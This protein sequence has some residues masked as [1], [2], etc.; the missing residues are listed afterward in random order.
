MLKF[1]RGRKR[2]RNAVLVIFI[3]VLTLSL[4]ALFSASGSGARM[5]GGTAGSDTVIA[6][7]GSY[8]VTVQDL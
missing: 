7:V 8:A 4:V 1:L 3:G 6:K 5:L 2:A